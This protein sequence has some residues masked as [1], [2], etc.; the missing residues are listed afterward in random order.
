MATNTSI[1][2]NNGVNDQTVHSVRSTIYD[3]DEQ[4]TNT[5]SIQSSL[6][7]GI[8]GN[9]FYF[10]CPQIIIVFMNQIIHIS[11]YMSIFMYIIKKTL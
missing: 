7:E 6:Y 9:Y 1:Q 5:R 3:K 10:I 4:I 11:N 8:F 2:E